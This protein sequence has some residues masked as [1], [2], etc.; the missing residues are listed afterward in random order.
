VWTRLGR[1]SRLLLFLCLGDRVGELNNILFSAGDR[2]ILCGL[3]A[4][5]AGLRLLDAPP[6]LWRPETEGP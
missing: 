4:G 5:P 1:V 6:G 2:G 3:L